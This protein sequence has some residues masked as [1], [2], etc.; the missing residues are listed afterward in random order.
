MFSSMLWSLQAVL[1][2]WL[3]KNGDSE[4]LVTHDGDEMLQ[5]EVTGPPDTSYMDNAKHNGSV[6]IRHEYTNL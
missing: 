5:K 1:I 2:L 6:F 3:C 4:K